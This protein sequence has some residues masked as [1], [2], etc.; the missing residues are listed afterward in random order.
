MIIV[1][2]EL[3]VATKGISAPLASVSFN[4]IKLPTL[5]FVKAVSSKF[6]T[7]SLNVKVISELVAIEAVIT[8]SISTVGGNLSA[9]VKIP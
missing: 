2:A 4:V 3:I 8:A 7:A 5:E 9:A 6:L 1:L